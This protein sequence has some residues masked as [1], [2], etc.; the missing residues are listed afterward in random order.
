MGKKTALATIKRFCLAIEKRGIKLKQ[1][2]LYGSFATGRHTEGSDIDLIV[3][4]DDFF[5]KGYWERIDI[6]AAVIYEI[7]AP[8]EALAYTSREW[9]T[10]DSLIKT[11]AKK[12]QVVYS[13]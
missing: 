5:G 4:S 9:K 11:F 10:T 3:I 1:V 13:A 7:F 2:I 12:G 6:L 8:V